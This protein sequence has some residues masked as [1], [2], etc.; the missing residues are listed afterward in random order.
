MQ[1]YTNLNCS[2]TV[3]DGQPYEVG[4]INIW[5]HK[6]VDLRERFTTKE[7]VYNQTLSVP[8]FEISNGIKSVRFGATE[9]SN[10]VWKIY[11][12]YEDSM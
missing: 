9:V 6:W 3:V 2:A 10:C 11:T 7:L 5:S 4:G 12:T 1:S 8:V